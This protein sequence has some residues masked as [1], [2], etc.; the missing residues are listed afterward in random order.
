V[1]ATFASLLVV[2]HTPIVEVAQPNYIEPIIPVVP[3]NHFCQREILTKNPRNLA[4]IEIK[5][6][7]PEFEVEE[8]KVED[9]S[10]KPMDFDLDLSHSIENQIIALHP[11]PNDSREFKVE[12]QFETSMS[13][14]EEGPHLDLTDWKHYISD[15]QEIKRLEGNRFL[16]S[17]ISESDYERFPKVTS[18][19]IYEAVLKRGGKRLADYARSCKTSNDAP[20]LVGISRISFRI[21]A[22][23]NGKWNVIHK[24]NVFIPMGC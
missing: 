6:F 18:K 9:L 19:E 12:Q 16:T 2:N 4:A 1:G 24:I 20:C 17:K 15:W 21:K 23:E 22:K 8:I 10:D 11:Y 5:R 7:D 14:S 3:V 13:V